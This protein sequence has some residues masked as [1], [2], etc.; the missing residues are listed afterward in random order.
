MFKWKVGNLW[1]KAQDMELSRPRVPEGTGF[2]VSWTKNSSESKPRDPNWPHCVMEAQ[3]VSLHTPP[4]SHR[5]SASLWPAG[6][7]QEPGIRTNV[8]RTPQHPA[9]SNPSQHSAAKRPESHSRHLPQG[10]VSIGFFLSC[11][12]SWT[13]Q[14]LPGSVTRMCQR[15]P[16]ERVSAD[17]VFCFVLFC[18]R[19]FF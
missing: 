1:P 3:P 6:R 12:E 9:G 7:P 17:W 18:W 14:S 19:L 5:A 2:I 11:P 4:I 16:R 15:L 10:L 8:G 13:S